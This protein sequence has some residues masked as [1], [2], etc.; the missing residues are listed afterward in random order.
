VIN[1]SSCCFGK[2]LLA[3]TGYGQLAATGAAGVFH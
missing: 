2:H 3:T 1:T